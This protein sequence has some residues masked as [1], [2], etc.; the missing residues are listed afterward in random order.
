[1]TPAE[2]AA[3]LRSE[4]ERHNRLY[5]LEEKP[6]ISDTEFDLLFRELQAL[7]E[8]Y[9]E[10]R[11]P[12]SP[13]QRV[14]APPVERFESHTHTVPMLSLDNAFTEEELRAFDARCRKG[15]GREGS[16][17][18]SAE[19]KFDGLSIALI[20]QDRVLAVAA[21]RGDGFTGEVVTANARTVRGVPLSLSDGAPD[22]L[23][24]RGEVVMYKADFEE[25]NRLRLEA[26]EEPFVNPRNAASGGM[27]QK[28]SRL[29]AR[30]RLRFMP[31]QVVNPPENVGTQCEALAWLGELGFVVRSNP[32]VCD[33]I[34]DLLRYI[35]EA[36]NAGRRCPLALTEWSSRSTRFRNRN[37]WASRPAVP[38]GR[39]P[40][41]IPPNKP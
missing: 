40:T 2:R 21:T 38:D 20:Y 29:T 30:R 13:T 12:D 28:D 34:G 25:L 7:E 16:V 27:R 6:E 18:Y 11:T 4:I 15:L 41:S 14:G 1:M 35:E 22:R 23:E 31:Y 19:Y 5:Y 39:S 24:V 32:R 9:P 17:Q 3:F 33:G 26:G 36:R 10:L 37:G 8:R